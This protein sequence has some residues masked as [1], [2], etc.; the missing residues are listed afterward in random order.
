MS[1]EA[2]NTVRAVGETTTPETVAAI[3]AA[4]E[5]RNDLPDDFHTLPV[6]E[7]LRIL[8]LEGEA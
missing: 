5:L 2:G 8:N 1:V 4:A 7:R 3:V 6:P